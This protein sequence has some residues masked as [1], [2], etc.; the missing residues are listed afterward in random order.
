MKHPLGEPVTD[1]I[2]HP[3]LWH[4]LADPD[5]HTHAQQGYGLPPYVGVRVLLT[6]VAWCCI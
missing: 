4:W 1:Q 5:L 3:G 2:S 6:S